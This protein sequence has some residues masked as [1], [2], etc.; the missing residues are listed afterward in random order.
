MH[1]LHTWEKWKDIESG[2]VL[3]NSKVKGKYAIQSRVC[4]ICGKKQFNQVK[5][6]II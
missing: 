6:Y 4:T 3:I 5:M 2:D 1:I